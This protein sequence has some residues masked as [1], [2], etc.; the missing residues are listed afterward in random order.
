M[1]YLD[2]CPSDVDDDEIFA[3]DLARQPLVELFDAHMNRLGDRLREV[4][5]PFRGHGWGM[6]AVIIANDMVER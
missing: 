3:S 6:V 2:I 4:I 5:K 1:T